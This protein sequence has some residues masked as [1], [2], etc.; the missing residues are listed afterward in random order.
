MSILIKILLEENINDDLELTK[1]IMKDKPI[2]NLIFEPS[3]KYEIIW[4]TIF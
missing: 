2:Y 1:L 3:N 4:F